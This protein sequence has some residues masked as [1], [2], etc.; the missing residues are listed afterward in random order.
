MRYKI[1]SRGSKFELDFSGILHK[2]H[3][4]PAW[5][6]EVCAFGYDFKSENFQNFVAITKD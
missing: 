5:Y 4:C 1:W 6:L 3:D 2:I